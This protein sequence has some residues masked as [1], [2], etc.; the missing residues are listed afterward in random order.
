MKLLDRY[1]RVSLL[2]FILVIVITGVV[3]YFTI[4]YILT[5][6]VDKDLVVE[7]NEIFD[8][9]KLNNRLP[10]VFKSD[11]LKIKFEP[12]SA[13]TVVRRF[14]NVQFYD[15]Q[16]NE[17]ELGR[18]LAT[19]VKVNK[20][21]YR[22]TIIESTVEIDYLIRMIFFIT[23]GLIIVLLIILLLLNRLLVRKLWQP[24]YQTLRQIKLFNLADR[25]VIQPVDTRIDE[26]HDL[27]NEVAAMSQ[28]VLYDY[29]SL[30]S[31]T[32]NASH[33]LMTPLAVIISKL[34]ILMQDDDVTEKQG[35]LIGEAYATVDRLKK[36][37]RS[38]L[39]LSR[40]EN[41]LMS[42]L[43]NIDLCEFIRNKI[44]E[45]QELLADR[46]ITLQDELQHCHININR[47][48]LNIMLNNLLGNAIQHNNANGV[49]VVKL[50]DKSMSI[51]NSGA[52]SPLNAQTIFQ[53]FHKSPESEGTGLGLTLV[54][55]ICDNY[56]F[57]LNYNFQDRLHCFTVNF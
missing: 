9:V 5:N 35:A 23:L 32:E 27:N 11:D 3:Y 25:N 44:I 28:R 41:K 45:F 50:T 21:T 14:S 7:E 57:R 34:E 40:I 30:K 53:R 29:Q 31:F 26:F 54:K 18:M 42:D 48:L 20:Q 37:S 15:E 22:V 4:S 16:E 1:N 33:E 38:M 10:Q 36:L 52:S 6:Q 24:F 39:L 55:Q 43:E 17:S 56:Q 49:I 46:E 8:H 12:I 2:T 51:C 13:D 19:S 47:D